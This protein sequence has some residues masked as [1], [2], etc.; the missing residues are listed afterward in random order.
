MLAL[1]VPE[2]VLQ[3][4]DVR[5]GAGGLFVDV[6]LALGEGVLEGFE[7]LGTGLLDELDQVVE[8]LVDHSFC[9]LL[10]NLIVCD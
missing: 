4:G 9:F 8:S 6:G 3:D 5:G 1:E 2:D 10:K 7:G